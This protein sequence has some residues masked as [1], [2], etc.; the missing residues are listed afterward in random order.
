MQKKPKIEGKKTR[1]I[2]ETNKVNVCFSLNAKKAF[3][4]IF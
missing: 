1:I 2:A 4:K 3:N